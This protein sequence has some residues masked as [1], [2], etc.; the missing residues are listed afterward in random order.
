MKTKATIIILIAFISFAFKSDK[1]AYRIFSVDGKNVKYERML[2]KLQKADVVLFGELHNNPISHW[3]QIELTKSLYDVKK[4]Q[5]VLGAEMF[6]TDN[7]LILDEYLSGL[8]SENKFETEARIWPNYKTDYKPL[9]SF[10]K[11][12]NLQFVAANVPRRYASLV[13]K[14]GFEGLEKLS[15]EAKNFIPELPIKY[16]PELECYKSMMNMGGGGMSAHKTSNFPKA[17][18]IKDATMAGSIL[19]YWKKGQLFLHYNGAYH[20]NNYESMVWYLKQ[21]NPNLKVMTI[22]TVEQDELKTLSEESKGVADFIIC[23]HSSMTKT[24]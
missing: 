9:V 16:N 2:K 12:N 4:E 8:I 18:A 14:N 7:Q 6:E 17:Q 3:L 22:S 21:A 23:V 13:F 11:E 24:H 1:P 15:N 5:L 20:S 10:A 19:K